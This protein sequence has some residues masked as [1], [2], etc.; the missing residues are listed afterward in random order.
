MPE[1]KHY[2]RV[3]VHDAVCVCLIRVVYFVYIDSYLKKII[4]WVCHAVKD[5]V[6]LCVNMFAVAARIFINKESICSTIMS[7]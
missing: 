3:K 2:K 1:R 6:Y 4:E 7:I 5:K